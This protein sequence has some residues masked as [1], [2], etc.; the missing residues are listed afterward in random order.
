MVL[1]LQAE[2]AERYNR[3]N[4]DTKNIAVIR[5]IITCG[6]I[7]PCICSNHTIAINMADCL[8][9]PLSLIKIPSAM[10][11]VWNYFKLQTDE[12]GKILQEKEDKPVFQTCKKAAPAKGGNTMNLL[13]QL[14]DHQPEL[15]TEA[16]LSCS[17]ATSSSRCQPTLQLKARKYLCICRT[18]VPSEWI[19]NNSGC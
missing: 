19:F 11:V 16:A 6:H 8:E 18:S 15:Y 4:N 12:D 3:L 10:S 5:P 1:L 9:D 17:R 13:T 7:Y 14:R 2:I